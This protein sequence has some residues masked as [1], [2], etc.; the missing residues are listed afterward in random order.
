MTSK[1]LEKGAFFIAHN[2]AMTI[3]ILLTRC[4]VSTKK[5]A[6]KLRENL[7]NL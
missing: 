7:H 5:L 4:G 3:V 6:N 2:H 1:L